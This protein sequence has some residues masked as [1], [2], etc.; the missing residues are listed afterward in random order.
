MSNPSEQP[1]SNLDDLDLDAIEARTDAAT[2]DPWGVEAV[3][4]SLMV[5][6]RGH[7]TVVAILGDLSDPQARPDAEFIAHA[8]ADVPA[9]V[10]EV[11]RL[12]AELATA[13][14]QERERC[15]DALWPY[16][17]AS[18]DLG[19][20]R[21]VTTLDEI[22]EAIRALGDE[23]IPAAAPPSV[24]ITTDDMDEAAEDPGGCPRCQAGVGIHAEVRGGRIDWRP[25][26][27]HTMP[28]ADAPD[29]D[30]GA[31]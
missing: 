21:A 26:R 28:C 10:A 8:R 23:D 25:V 2:D 17:E 30:T 22:Q 4:S 31:R 24:L 13:R 18:A 5:M 19:D 16:I 20:G 14:R 6:H 12:R 15:A 9:L 29:H 3:G 1:V 27:I 7:C 11:R